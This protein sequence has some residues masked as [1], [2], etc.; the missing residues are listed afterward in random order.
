MLVKIVEDDEVAAEFQTLCGAF[1]FLDSEQIKKHETYLGRR[2]KRGL[3]ESGQGLKLNADINGAGNILRKGISNAFSLWEKDELI[4]GFCS[5][6]R[7][8]TPPQLKS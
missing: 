3:F 6:P 7:R 5:Y 2:V 1:S 4:K 8:L